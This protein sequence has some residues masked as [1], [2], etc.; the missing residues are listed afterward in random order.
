MLNNFEQIED[1]PIYR[2]EL[3]KES[4]DTIS[5]DVNVSLDTNLNVGNTLVGAI[6]QGCEVKLETDNSIL[7]NIGY[8]SL[9]KMS[10][11]SDNV[12]L[13][14][15]EAW[16]VLQ[17]QND[18]NPLHVH[19]SFLSGILYIDVPNFIGKKE[20]KHIASGKENLDGY[21]VFLNGYNFITIKPVAGEG[22]IFPSNIPHMVYPFSSVGDRI[23]VAWN[24]DAKL[25]K[26]IVY[27]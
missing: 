5:N 14:V 15:S 7:E 20:E 4:F 2:F 10:S 23:S 25:E 3:S 11:D 6:Y 19:S 21:L 17:K 27:R 9:D 24:L 8:K 16:T 12:E 13:F 22:Y 18:Y 1:L 26:Q